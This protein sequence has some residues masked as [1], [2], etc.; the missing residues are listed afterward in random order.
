MLKLSTFINVCVTICSIFCLND[1][2]IF[3]ELNDI[4][5]SLFL[6]IL[7]FSSASMIFPTSFLC[8]LNGLGFAMIALGG[9]ICRIL[10]VWKVLGGSLCRILRVW[11]DL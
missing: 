3:C 1:N 8:V 5:S 9:S 2:S 4:G 11:K 7:T 10:R 6:S